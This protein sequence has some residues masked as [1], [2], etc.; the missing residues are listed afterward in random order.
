MLKKIVILFV[1]SLILFSCSSTNELTISVTEPAPV[2]IS[3]EVTKIGIINRSKPTENSGLALDIADKLL[4]G[5]G[6]TL[7]KDGA[8]A[9]TKAVFEELKRMN[10][11][12]RITIVN[13]PTIKSNELSSFPAAISWRDIDRI[14]RENNV[15]VLFELSFYDTDTEIDYET[16]KTKVKTPLGDVPA[17][18]HYAHVTTY[19]KSGWR[20]YDATTNRIADE[21]GLND[22]IMASGSGINPVKAIEAITG[23][24]AAVIDIS[25]Q[26]GSDYAQ[27]ILPYR[28]R[29]SRDY[30]VKGNDN[31]E[32]AMRR[33]RTGDWEGAAELWAIEVNNPDDK[34][35]GRA[36]YNMAIINEIN[37]NLDKAIEW[38]SK[39]Y[40]DYEIKEGMHYTK[41]LRE[42]VRKNE[43]LE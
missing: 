14:C 25:R 15:E 10:K 9:A 8:D 30:F 35:A 4:S 39:S 37:G 21:I 22:R 31:F 19:I 1:L 7:D 24:K 32:K 38:A 2:Y 36:C 33:A 23:R 5:E 43:M 34:I 29:V 12:S 6:M 27:R 40:A 28:T 17:L 11:F 26:I 42:R 41:I 13:D 3:K 18:H 16:Q 20:I